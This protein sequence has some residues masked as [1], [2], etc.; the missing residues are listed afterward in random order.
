MAAAE[1]KTQI[2]PQIKTEV[3]DRLLEIARHYDA[4]KYWVVNVLLQYGTRHW[5][6]AMDEYSRL[7]KEQ[8]R[9]VDD[10]EVAEVAKE[11]PKVVKLTPPGA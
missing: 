11:G 4:D 10:D 9:D 5:K 8:G 7:A 6:T 2:N 3:Y 1:G